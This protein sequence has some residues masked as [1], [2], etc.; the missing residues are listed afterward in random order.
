MS[1][2]ETVTV[3][4]VVSSSDQCDESKCVSYI[5]LN[6][7]NTTSYEC[8]ANSAWIHMACSDG[9]TPRIVDSVPVIIDTMRMG[10]YTVPD[11]PYNYFTCCPPDLPKKVNVTRHCSNPTTSFY[12]G[13]DGDNNNNSSSNSSSSSSSSSTIHCKDKNRPYPRQMASWGERESFLC[14][15]SILEY[16][17]ANNQEAT[18]ANY[19]ND[20][21]CVPFIDKR[22]ISSVSINLYGN[23]QPIT[24]DAN[25]GIYSN[26]RFPQKIEKNN[27][28]GTYVYECCKTGT[29]LPPFIEDYAFN[30]SIYPQIIISSIAVCSCTLLILALIIPLFLYLK[31]RAER[32]LYTSTMID[33]SAPHST[34]TS[35][36]TSRDR[37]HQPLPEPPY[38]S[39][40]LYLVYLALPDLMLNM[41]YIIMYSRYANQ[42]YHPHN[43]NSAIIYN[44]SILIRPFESSFVM[45]CLTADLYLNCVV[46]NEILTLLRD[47]YNVTRYNSPSYF[48]VSLQAA[49]VCIFSILV[50]VIHY[51]IGRAQEKAY[52]I[53]DFGQYTYLANVNFYWS[54]VI[55]Y[56]FPMIFFGYV[57]VT[58]WCRGYMKSAAGKMKQL[59]CLFLFVILYLK[60]YQ[61]HH[62][63]YLQ[64]YEIWHF[65]QQKYSLY[66]SFSQRHGTS[67][68]YLLSSMPSGCQ[69]CF[70]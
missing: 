58:I 50:F 53:G 24:C 47:S 33:I 32:A 10:T 57:W 7:S 54:I 17:T 2:N 41:Y 66:L 35:T 21:Q 65:C 42:K 36:T 38:N 70:S 31:K 4:L 3:L 52:E 37:A 69:G 55:S 14:C 5:D 34:C 15:D 27:S 30:T 12:Q 48:K 28:Y 6:G 59:V 64:K 19:L 20:T 44:G 22:F 18:N 67:F 26:F 8:Y 39:F 62:S 13:T 61:I 63:L 49:T 51:F 1:N 46:S 60:P 23:I 43:I 45:A 68:V 9:Y 25:Q 16:T 29:T 11:V 40:V 56:I